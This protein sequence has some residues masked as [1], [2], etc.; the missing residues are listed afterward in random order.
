MKVVSIAGSCCLFFAFAAAVPAAKKKPVL[1][2]EFILVPSGTYVHCPDGDCSSE[3]H[4]G[5]SPNRNAVMSAYW[6]KYEVSNRQFR[7]FLDALSPGEQAAYL[8][9]ST[10]WNKI[11]RYGEPYKVNYFRHP[12]YSNYPVVTISHAAAI[13][14]CQWLQEKIQAVNPAY[15]IEVRLPT[16][17]EWTFAAMSFSRSNYS[18][19]TGEHIQTEDGS[20][21]CNFKVV[22]NES[23]Y[24]DSA[25][26]I[27][28]KSQREWET[29]NGFYF[30]PVK[31]YAPNGF[32]LYNMCGNAAEM[33][34]Q[35]SVCL[36]GS[37]NDYGYDVRIWSEARYSGPSPFVGFRPIVHAYE[38]KKPD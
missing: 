4:E 6:S 25:G 21:R 28:V 34:D 15:R 23:I 18:W 26:E 7:D 5:L 14:Y 24:R 27:Q 19:K 31:S 8:P 11:V 30:T 32:K 38:I 22:S 36:G 13:R 33:I 17:Y 35:D 3:P 12:A 20:Y 10:C 29:Q 2:E 9:D 37:W 16:R 1:P